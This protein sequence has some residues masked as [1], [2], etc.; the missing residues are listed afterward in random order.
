MA[1]LLLTTFLLLATCAAP[2]RAVT[3]TLQVEDRPK[4]CE[5]ADC[6]PAS[7]FARLLVAAEPAEA[8]DVTLVNEGST[9]VV[10][11]AVGALTAGPGCSASAPGTVRCSYPAGLGGDVSAVLRG[12]G[13]D[14]RFLVL[15]APG[16][17]SFEGGGGDDVLTSQRAAN[18]GVD[19]L[20]GGPGAD[21]LSGGP[22]LDLMTGGP[23]A[24]V[25]RGEEGDDHLS[26]DGSAVPAP[27]PADPDVLDGGPGRDVVSWGGQ[28]AP[29]RVD[30]ADPGP[31]GATGEG[32]QLVG[33]EDVEGGRG[34]DVLLGDDGPNRLLAGESARPE[35]DS[36][37][38]VVDGRGGNDELRASAQRGGAGDDVL[39]AR[40]RVD[41]GTGRDTVLN[42]ERLR[43]FTPACERGEIA[44]VRFDFRLR[45]VG[46]ALRLRVR[47]D[48]GSQRVRVLAATSPRVFAT[49]ESGL[50]GTR[51][52][53]LRLNR[54]GRRALARTKRIRL[55]IDDA[56]APARIG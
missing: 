25:L 40:W 21:Q 18:Q 37:G 19:T 39:D 17:V 5:G 10:Q 46:A 14:D 45:R 43:T 20:D 8:V 54:A 53:T 48:G 9:F 44:G 30:L 3:A 32:D 6:S 22:G 42:A 35:L 33:V 12:G 55:Q 56:K 29:V 36:T 34:A 23:G 52:L 41:C 11:A 47:V 15:V 4:Y 51:T 38:D 7:R 28:E 13:A 1:R 2:A 27:V 16:P 50:D 24:D 49:E 26:G 31:D